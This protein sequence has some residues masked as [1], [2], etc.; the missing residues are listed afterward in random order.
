MKLAELRRRFLSPIIAI[1][2]EETEQYRLLF[3]LV[4]VLVVEK[5]GVME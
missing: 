4:L 3:L 5:T 1:A 2:A